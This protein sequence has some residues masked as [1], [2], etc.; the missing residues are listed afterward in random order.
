MNE[1]M[2]VFCV[3]D[4]TWLSNLYFVLDA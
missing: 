1:V 4:E 3:L 2:N